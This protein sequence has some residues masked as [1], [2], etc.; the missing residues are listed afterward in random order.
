MG[1]KRSYK[2]DTLNLLS[3]VNLRKNLLINLT[4][5]PICYGLIQGSLIKANKLVLQQGGFAD[6]L[7]KPA[8]VAKKE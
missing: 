3:N 8:H 7:S 4:L 2:L 5:T 1:T 6:R